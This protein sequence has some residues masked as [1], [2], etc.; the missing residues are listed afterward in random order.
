MINV[1]VG[2]FND[3]IRVHDAH[4]EPSCETKGDHVGK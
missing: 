1:L 4:S 2:Q 3:S